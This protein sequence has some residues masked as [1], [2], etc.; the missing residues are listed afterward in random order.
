MLLNT[1]RGVLPIRLL[2]VGDQR[3]LFEAL[4]ARLSARP[5]IIVV[6]HCTTRDPHPDGLA[7]VARPDV[8]ALEIAQADQAAALFT[9]FRA[10]WPPARF[11][12]LTASRDPDQAI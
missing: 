8:I 3:M 10:A 7:T 6:G 2:L 12:M 11:V 1:V 9:M 5:E 4:A